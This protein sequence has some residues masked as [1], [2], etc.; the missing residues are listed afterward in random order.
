MFLVGGSRFWS[1]HTKSDEASRVWELASVWRESVVRH[2]VISAI[3]AKMIEIRAI[4][5]TP[6]KPSR[7]PT[8][9][10]ANHVGKNEKFRKAEILRFALDDVESV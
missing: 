2:P 6:I 10:S 8:F 5:K 9:C 3:K 1:G 7:K 4:L